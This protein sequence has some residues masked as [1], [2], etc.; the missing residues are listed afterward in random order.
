MVFVANG[1]LV[2][3]FNSYYDTGDTGVNTRMGAQVL[4]ESTVF[5]GVTDPIESKDSDTTG[6]AVAKDVELGKGLNT[7]PK[8]TLTSVPY[9]YSLLGS[10]KVKASVVGTAGNTLTLA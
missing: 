2:H 8:G 5:T 7:A 3:V 9:T 1:S 6:Y 10:A 4:V